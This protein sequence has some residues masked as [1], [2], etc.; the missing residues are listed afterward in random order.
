MEACAAANVGR[1]ELV[2]TAMPPFVD[3]DIIA[4][5]H[6]ADVHTPERPRVNCKRALCGPISGWHAPGV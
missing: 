6:T 5:E 3:S 1:I 4:T 2:A